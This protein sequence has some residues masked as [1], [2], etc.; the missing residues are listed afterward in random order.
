[1]YKVVYLSP[2][3]PSYNI[4]ETVKFFTDLF[5]FQLVRDESNYA[6]VYK[7]GHL[8]HFL[9]A[10]SDIGEMELYLEVDNIDELWGSI[11]DKLPDVKSKPP[12]DREYGMREF[13]II[14]PHTKT[15]LFVGQ[16]IR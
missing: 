11:K 5:G 4:P 14:I 16:V 2:M 3:V 10:G 7:D 12:F 9:N 13:H 6:I 15:L 1:M 8:I